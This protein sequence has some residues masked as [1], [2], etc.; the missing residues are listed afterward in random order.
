MV[1]RFFKNFILGRLLLYLEQGFFFSSITFLAKTHVNALLLYCLSLTRSLN[2]KI[3]LCVIK[4]IF[5]C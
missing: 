1:L 5:A 4:E 2:E 3:R